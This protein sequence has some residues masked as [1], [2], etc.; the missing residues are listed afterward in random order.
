MAEIEL[1]DVHLTYRIYGAKSRSLKAS[2][3][4]FATGGALTKQQDVVEVNALKNISLHL[5]PGDRLGLVGHNG[6]GKTTLLKLL[7]QIYE[8][9]QGRVTISGTT[10][11]LFDLMTGMEQELTGYENILLRGAILGIPKQTILKAVPDIEEFADLGD[12][13]KVPIKSY[14]AGMVVRLAFGIMTSIQSEIL[15][16]DEVIGVGD[17]GF[18]Q[19]AKARLENLVHRAD[20][21]VL[22]THD[23]AIIKELCNKVLVLEHGEMQYFGNADLVLR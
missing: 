14:S 2:A 20:I 3:L 15:L 16:I 11:C 19:K 23:H 12:F 18:M 7:A 21:L 6:A 10:N 17:A 5:K 8:P 13:M 4:R 9:S 22:S 1:E